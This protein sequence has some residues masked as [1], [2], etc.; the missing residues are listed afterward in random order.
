VRLENHSRF[1]D[2]VLKERIHVRVGEPL[3][4]ASMQRDIDQLYALGFLDTAT[5]QVV[6]DN[7]QR[8]VVI[9]V[10]QDSRGASFVETGLD[11]IGGPD[12]SSLNVRV[13]YLKTDV[14]PRGG[15]LR[16][17]GQ[18]GES[19]G[20][21]AELYEPIDEDLR[22]ILLPRLSAQRR[23]FD[24]F[25]DN[26][27]KVARVRIQEYGGSLAIG[28]EFWR[29]AA[30]FFGIRRYTGDADVEIGPPHTSDSYDGGEWFANATWDRL[31]DRYFPSSGTA[32][33]F[34]Y[35]WSETNL[36]ADR[37]FE[38]LDTSFFNAATWGRNTWFTS[39]RY[40]TTLHS[41]AP[42][43]NLFT[44]GGP[45]R[46]SGLEPDQL[47]GEH[48]GMALL[49]YRVKLV[50][51]GLLPPYAGA[52]VEYGNAAEKRHNIIDDGLWNGSLYVGFNT[53][54]GPLYA[55]YGLAEG[56]RRSYYLRIGS[57]VGGPQSLGR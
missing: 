53:P 28:R 36:G 13:G 43:Q 8:G 38:Q 17:L 16:L 48:Y 12:Q 32:V 20:L 6:N 15:E 37:N 44:L 51:S 45:F 33:T 46:L 23:S 29:H 2:E 31:D 41:D 18:V 3:D 10:D 1:S 39:M 55:G 57:L 50:Q 54:I 4:S 24:L 11:F 22:I 47:V 7:G 56:D 26:G 21:L 14:D 5:Y 42:L 25:D 40:G 34:N 30:I 52:T 35:T 49:G 19:Q 27:D 9:R